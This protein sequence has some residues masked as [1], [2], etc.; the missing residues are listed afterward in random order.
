MRKI[1]TYRQKYIVE[2]IMNHKEESGETVYEVKWVNYPHSQNTW[3]PIRH[4][5]GVKYLVEEY[6][7]KRLSIYIYIYIKLIMY[8]EE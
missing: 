6:N 2:G 3:E 1:R 5:K 7:N 8:R 4:L